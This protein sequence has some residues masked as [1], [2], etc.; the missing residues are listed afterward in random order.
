MKT[1]KYNYREKSLKAPF[2]IYGEKSY[3]DKKTK[4]TPSGYSLFTNCSFDSAKNKL[5]C[6]TGKGRIVNYEKKKTNDTTNWWRKWALWMQKVSY[7]CKKIFSTDKNDENAFK[8]YHKV[9]DHCHYTEKFNGAADNI[10]NLR[11]KTPKKKKEFP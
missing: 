6:Y 4:H 3:T 1:T 2:I 7:K 10:C 8:L 9:K 5:D 11:Y